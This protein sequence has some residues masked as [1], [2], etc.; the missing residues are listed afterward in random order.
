MSA[1]KFHEDKAKKME[2]SMYKADDGKPGESLGETST[3]ELSRTLAA[4]KKRLKGSDDVGLRERASSIE[5]ELRKRVLAANQ[6]TKWKASSRPDAG[7]G[8]DQWR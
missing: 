3:K 6:R 8:Y 1:S 5:G 7:D 2:K 4:I